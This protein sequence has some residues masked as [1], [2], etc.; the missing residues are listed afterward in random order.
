M[1]L[2]TLVRICAGN[3]MSFLGT[4]GIDKEP[5]GIDQEPEGLKKNFLAF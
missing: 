5:G 1:S 4:G 3:I 2:G